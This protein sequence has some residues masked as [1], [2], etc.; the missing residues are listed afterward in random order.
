[1]TDTT[2]TTQTTSTTDTASGTDAVSIP[3]P[4]RTDPAQRAGSGSGIRTLLAERF[5]AQPA[6]VLVTELFIGF[7][8]LRA[9]VEKMIDPGWWNGDVIDGFVDSHLDASLGWYTPFASGVV[10]PGA[11]L[12]AVVVVVAQLVAAAGLLSGRRLGLSLAVGIFL[13]LHFMAAGAV[14]PSAF[15]LL[16]QGA[17]VLWL[18]ER[19]P[20]FA[21]KRKLGLAAVAAAVLAL[22]S[23]P[24]ISTIQ[25][26][27]VIE[28]PAIMYVT[29][30]VLTVL[31]CVRASS[32][33]SATR[34]ENRIRSLRGGTPSGNARNLSRSCRTP[35]S[36]LQD[37]P[38]SGF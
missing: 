12:V 33:I 27:L 11:L 6:W 23:V 19:R 9:A 32:S 15:Y 21:M 22:I 17:L 29:A 5:S 18:A 2:S 38:Q 26:A 4:A 35:A 34:R 16:A 3:D 37:D 13:N 1:M 10:L 14:N 24:F 31:A 36:G 25:P 8:W 28:D 30:G 20:T 7:G